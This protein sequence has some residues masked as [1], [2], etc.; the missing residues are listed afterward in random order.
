KIINLLLFIVFL[1]TLSSCSINNKEISVF[2]YDEN[3]IF[4]NQLSQ[5]LTKN[6]SSKYKITNYYANKSQVKQNLQVDEVLHKSSLVLMNMVDRLAS[7]AVV[8]KC[9]KENIPIIFFN[10]EPLLED[11]VDYDN[12]YYVGPDPD[13]QG[14]LQVLCAANIFGSPSSLN[15]KYDLNHDNKI[16]FVLLKGEQGH[17][18]AERR[19]QSCLSNIKQMGYDVELISIGVCNWN[20]TEAYNLLWSQYNQTLKDVELILANN[21]EMAIGAATFLNE[22]KASPTDSIIPVIGVDATDAGIEA[23]NNKLLASTIINEKFIYIDSKIYG[24]DGEN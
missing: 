24:S 2:Y 23:V 22:K 1:A 15:P 11:L 17:Q 19:T 5:K 13:K 12:C 21:D 3:D 9:K 14:K 20:R 8:E 4:L 18:D 6:L 16:Q 7:G 10:R